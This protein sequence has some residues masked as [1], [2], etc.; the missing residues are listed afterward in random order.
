MKV[1]LM[2]MLLIALMT[3]SGSAFAQTT[4]PGDAVETMSSG[5]INWTVGE[6]YAT[7]IGAPPAQPV[8]RSAGPRHGRTRRLCCCAPEPAR[9]GKRGS[10][11]L[12][13]PSSRT[14]WS[15]SDVIRTRV[16]GIV[17]GARIIKTQYMSDGSVEMLVAMPLKGALMDTIVPETFRKTC[18]KSDATETDSDPAKTLGRKALTAAFETR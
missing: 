2:I 4:G 16:D 18:R 5:K 9:S 14:S 10:R 7:G 11:G 13:D 12:R 8:Q 1:H 6:V 17:K 3:V 15:K